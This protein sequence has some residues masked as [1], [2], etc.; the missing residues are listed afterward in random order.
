MLEESHPL[1]PYLPKNARILMLGSFPPPRARWSMD[2]YYP[3]FQNDFWRIVG[4]VIYGNKNYFVNV[5]EKRFNKYLITNF[6]S[7]FG[8]ALYD[9][10]E[11]IVR[12]KNNASDNFLQVA[13]PVDLAILLSQ[14]PDCQTIAVTGEKAADTLSKIIDCEKPAIGTSRNLFYFDREITIWRMPS[15]SRAYPLPLTKKAQYYKIL[16]DS[17]ERQ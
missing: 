4:C 15:T 8:M 13:K 2:F 7:N 3:N 1:E 17:L 16:F 12:L 6:C 5:T 9:T 11:S 10:A 14:I